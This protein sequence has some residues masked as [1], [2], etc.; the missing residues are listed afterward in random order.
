MR[1]ARATFKGNATWGTSEDEQGLA[2]TNERLKA[3]FRHCLVFM[4]LLYVKQATLTQE[5]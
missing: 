2:G 3:P 1:W 4:S 5:V